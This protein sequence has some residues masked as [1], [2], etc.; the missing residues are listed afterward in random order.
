MTPT[1]WPDPRASHAGLVLL[2]DQYAYPNY[3]P[4]KRD[5]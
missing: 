5:R 3:K 1:P 4:R 2:A